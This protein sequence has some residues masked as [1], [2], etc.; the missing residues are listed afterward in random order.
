MIQVCAV[1]L[2]SSVEMN[3]QEAVCSPDLS[4][5][6]NSCL[7][8]PTQRTST[9]LATLRYQHNMMTAVL[10][11]LAATLH[12]VNKMLF[13]ITNQTAFVKHLPRNSLKLYVRIFYT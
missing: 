3:T 8:A 5:T 13:T 4:V 9:A 11:S 12:H 10:L 1:E 6:C 7:T 2:Q